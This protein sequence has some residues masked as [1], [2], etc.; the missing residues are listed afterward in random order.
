MK[1]GTTSVLL[2]CHSLFHSAVVVVAW[3]KWHKQWPR[4]W[5]FICILVHDLGHWG[6]QY[7]DNYEEK[8]EHSLLG[9]QIARK[10]FGEKGYLLV[11]GHN[12][13]MGLPRSTLYY[14]DKYSWVIAPLW[15]MVTNTIFEPKLKRRGYTRRQSA[16]MFKEAVTKNMETDFLEKG[17]EIYLRQW[18][19]KQP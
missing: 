17:H 15:W 14:P 10:L 1:Q 19:G 6:K 7:L 8:K 9:A 11:A 5:E 4:L 2:G 12:E 18:E 3:K 13:Y 16:L